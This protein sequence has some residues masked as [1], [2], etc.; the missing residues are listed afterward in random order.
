MLFTK[1]DKRCGCFFYL[2]SSSFFKKGKKGDDS[3]PNMA[4]GNQ[5]G[6]LKLKK[7]FI[8]LFFKE[9]LFLYFYYFFD[10][11]Q[12]NIS[13]TGSFSSRFRFESVKQETFDLSRVIFFSCV[14]STLLSER[15]LLKYFH[16]F[17]FP[18]CPHQ[19]SFTPFFYSLSTYSVFHSVLDL[20]SF[21]SA[22][23]LSP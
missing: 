18:F 16:L 5:K 4:Q 20:F 8:L 7:G 23:S 12:T 17:I 2:F 22:F 11:F 6:K 14:S 19:N 1:I 13:L 10:I 3:T 9:F 21:L 15:D